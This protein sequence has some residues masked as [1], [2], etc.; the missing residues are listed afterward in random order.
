M[1]RSWFDIIALL[2]CA[3]LTGLLLIALWRISDGTEFRRVDR[4]EISFHPPVEPAKPA[5]AATA[6]PTEAE[7]DPDSPDSPAGEQ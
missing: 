2:T 6:A 1:L 3:T 4:D 5:P 7:P